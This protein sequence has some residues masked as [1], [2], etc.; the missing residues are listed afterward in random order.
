[1]T[2]RLRRYRYFTW[3]FRCKR[4]NAMPFNRFIPKR[5]KV[6]YQDFHIIQKLVILMLLNR[7][8][9]LRNTILQI[10]ICSPIYY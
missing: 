5:I 6:N 3:D 2:G 4:F 10:P 8:I 9:T 1:M 7:K